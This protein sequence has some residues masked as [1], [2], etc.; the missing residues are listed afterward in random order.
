VI[1]RRVG[2]GIESARTDAGTV[3]RNGN[4]SGKEGKEG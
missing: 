4:A 2:N 3:R 1:L